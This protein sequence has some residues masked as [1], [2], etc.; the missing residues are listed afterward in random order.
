MSASSPPKVAAQ[1]WWLVWQMRQ[2]RG[3]RDDGGTLTI[4]LGIIGDLLC[5]IPISRPF[6]GYVM[7]NSE[8]FTHIPAPPPIP[9]PRG[10]TC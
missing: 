8:E 4:P 3:F 10:I 1:S 2:C 6:L 5:P 9:P 7:L